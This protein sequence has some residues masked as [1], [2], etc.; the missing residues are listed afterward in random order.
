MVPRTW[1]RLRLGQ[2]QWCQM[3]SS[4][5]N[6][7]FDVETIA[8]DEF[9]HVEGLD[10][11]VNYA[12]EHDYSDAVV[13]TVSRA[14]PASGWN[15][16]VRPVRH[17]DP[18]ARIRRAEQRRTKYSTCLDL[19]TVLSLTAAPASVAFGG[20]RRPS[21]PPSRWRA[22]PPTTALRATRSPAERSP[23]SDGPRVRRPGR[24]SVRCRPAPTR[25]VQARAAALGGHG[26]PRR[27][28]DAVRRGYQWRHV[29]GP[30]SVA[31]VPLPCTAATVSACLAPVRLRE[32]S[33][34]IGRSWR[35]PDRPRHACASRRRPTARGRRAPR[36]RA[37]DL[38]LGDI[39][40]RR[41]RGQRAPFRPPR[42]LPPVARLR[43]E[44]A[45][46]VAGQLGSYSDAGG[47]SDSPGYPARR[48]RPRRRRADP[49]LARGRV[50]RR[51][52]VG[53]PRAG[54]LDHGRGAVALADGGWT[55][56]SRHL[57][58]DRGPS[59]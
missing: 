10:H 22:A 42:G 23:S 3:H 7:C 25:H 33:R 57:A 14:R 31:A 18:P 28:Q 59:R 20:D 47:G 36:R 29:S 58:S 30:L 15:T 37:G 9:G 53:P 38:A 13:Q 45:D 21:R 17:R 41:P 51:R 26:V 54:R 16:H 6:G 46:P 19:S 1:A 52:L 8:L 12:D 34:D 39:D 49:D 5:P 4:P 43:V 35:R 55:W 32:R 27:L 48:S 56:P 40:G 44:G 24:P 50:G 11:H 2:P